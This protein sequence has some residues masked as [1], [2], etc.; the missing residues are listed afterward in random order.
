MDDSSH[1]EYN[2]ADQNVWSAM[3]EECHNMYP[4]KELPDSVSL[5]L[6]GLSKVVMIH[7]LQSMTVISSQSITTACQK[8]LRCYSRRYRRLETTVA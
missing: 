2:I 5:R 3:L 6:H 8:E 1:V 7:I 4:V